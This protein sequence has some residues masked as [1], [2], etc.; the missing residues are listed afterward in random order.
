MSLEWQKMTLKEAGVTLIDC[1][2][3]T[4]PAIEN[5]YPYIAIPQLKNGHIELDGVRRISTEHFLEW[6]KKLKPQADDVIV[7]RR[8]N[9]GDSAV[10]PK[11]LEC[12]IGQNL[13]VLRSDGKTLYPKLLRWLLRSPDWWEQVSKFI[14]VGAVFDSLKCKEIPYFELTIPP[15]SAQKEIT[16]ILGA[17]DDRITLLRET[18]ATLEAIAQ[19][20]FKSWF[21]DF[22]PVHAKMQGTQPEGMDEQTA[23]LFPD[24][25]EESELGLVPA[26]W[27]FST[28]QESFILTMGQSPP[29]HTY[30]E[31]G[32]GIPFYQG[33]TDFGFRFPSQ[34]IFCTSPTR[35]ADI[36]DVLVSVRAPVGDVNMALEKCCLGRGVAGLKHPKGYK[37]F[38]FYTARGLK[39]RFDLFDAE[40]TVFGSINK[41][42]FQELPVIQPTPD[43]MQVFDEIASPLDSKIIANERQIRTLTDLRDT[44][45]PR[46]ISGQLRVGEV[47]EVTT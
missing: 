38:A 27:E 23:A 44:L 46:L 7:V 42:D 17:L 32:E 18:N 1:D 31:S 45:L 2:H 47:E 26:G 13:V 33:R 6:T 21:V 15:M 43:V 11:G 25:F 10:I 22:D 37:S 20:L 9:S 35:Y 3:R 40:G 8:C 29:G 41:K 39:T 30:N 12:A 14:N 24:S 36:G 5:G 4:P 28:I 16:T 34:R 19:A